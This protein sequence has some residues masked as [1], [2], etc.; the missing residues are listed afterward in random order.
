MY[1]A[2]PYILNF[3][4]S[5]LLQHYLSSR[6]VTHEA[7][8]VSQVSPSLQEKLCMYVYDCKIFRNVRFAKE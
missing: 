7:F 3:I 6:K 2:N 8:I 5:E 1:I 4:V